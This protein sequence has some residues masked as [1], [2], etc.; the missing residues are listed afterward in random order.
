ME[1]HSCCRSNVDDHRFDGGAIDSISAVS[2]EQIPVVPENQQ[3]L[4]VGGS[5]YKAIDDDASPGLH[6]GFKLNMDKSS[7]LDRGDSRMI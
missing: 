5:L 3:I 1:E 6:N 2:T 4:N 7:I